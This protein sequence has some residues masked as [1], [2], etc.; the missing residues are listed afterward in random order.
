MKL[1]L[2]ARSE[3]LGVHLRDLPDEF[4]VF[5][6]LPGY[7]DGHPATWAP[8]RSEML[9]AISTNYDCTIFSAAA[10]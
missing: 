3:H 8:D 5:F 1:D 7:Y 2:S 9:R 6:T 10:L 4:T